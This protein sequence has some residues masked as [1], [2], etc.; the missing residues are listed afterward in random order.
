ME[1]GQWQPLVALQ[2]PYFDVIFIGEVLPK[3]VERVCVLKAEYD[4]MWNLAFASFGKKLDP[5]ERAVG[6]DFVTLQRG[7]KDGRLRLEIV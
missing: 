2:G 6:N 3:A 7:V 4:R 5:G 1:R